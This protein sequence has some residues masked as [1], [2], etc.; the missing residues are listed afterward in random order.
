[1]NGSSQSLPPADFSA[2]LSDALVALGPV[3]AIETIEE[4]V[5]DERVT[6]AEAI[7]TLRLLSTIAM[8][9]SVQNRGAWECVANR[10]QGEAVAWDA[11]ADRLED[12]MSISEEA[13]E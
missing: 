9:K 5:T 6:T 8:R 11:A 3:Y 10:K 12:S 1:M 7:A 2:D 13:A 4:W